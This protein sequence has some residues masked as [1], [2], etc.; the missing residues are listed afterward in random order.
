VTR[1]A[2]QDWLITGAPLMLGEALSQY[3]DLDVV[4][5]ERVT[6]ARRRMGL[7]DDAT[8]DAA[9][10]RR[11]AEE[12]G[13]WTAITGNVFASGKNL[14]LSV[15]ALDVPT[16]KVL[17]R[18][19]TE[20][21]AEADVR[22]A[23]DKLSVR[24]LEVSGVRGQ[25]SDVAA[26]T[27]QSVQAYQAYVSGV[28]LR[29][30]SAYRQAIASFKE[31][32]RLDSTFALAWAKLALTSID[33]NPLTLLDP[34]GAI[35]REIDQAA[36]FAT[37]LPARQAQEIRAMQAFYGGD[38]ARGRVLIDS[39]VATDPDD[40]ESLE[41][42][43]S[44]GMIDPRIDT[45]A[46]PPTMA[47]SMNHSLAQA[48]DVLERDPGRRNVYATLALSYGLAG[49]LWT[50]VRTGFQRVGPILSLFGQGTGSDFVPV[51]GDTIALVPRVLFDALPATERARSRRAGAE[52]AMQWVKRWLVAG[53]ADAD[54]HLWASRI[55]E[56]QEDFPL[57]LRE[58]AV[59]ESLGVQSTLES[60][61]GR[62]LVLLVRSGKF[63]AAAAM[64]ESVFVAGAPSNPVQAIIDRGVGYS[65]MSLLLAKRWSQAAALADRLGATGGSCLSIVNALTGSRGNP[66]T[67]GDLKAV[68]DTAAMHFTEVASIPSLAPC[69]GNF[70]VTLVL[71]S[72]AGRRTQAGAALLRAADSLHQAGNEI[73]AYRAAQ[74]MWRVDTARHAAFASR[75]W[76][77][78]KSRE[79]L[80]GAR[81]TAGAVTVTADSATFSFRQIAPG[82][83]TLNLVTIVTNWGMSVDMQ[84]GTG[85]TSTRMN[86]R[87]FHQRQTQDGDIRGGVPQMIQAMQTQQVSMT[88][89]NA[90]VAASR[91]ILTPTSEGFQVVLKGQALAALLRLKPASAVFSADICV[92][93]TDGL[94][95]PTSMA[96]QYR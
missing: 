75:A 45:T 37:R 2:A 5:E 33:G 42:S 41:M 90:A 36:R 87:L 32:T 30:R 15:Q 77:T 88:P 18:G 6:A 11:L 58:L 73:L 8:L 95:T 66:S 24:L 39:L 68:M 70:V 21:A 47:S 53:P 28:E 78:E 85:T 25:G 20:I 89:A 84:A 54:A 43:A 69:V 12:T 65:I 76:V 82:P 10:L 74:Y 60:V 44:L 96:I 17:V 14:R 94:C 31:A 64:A 62:R 3:R 48:R 56:V 83:M 34:D 46:S 7:K 55:A 51:M 63:D 67:Q 27:T 29:Q 1:A 13:G 57:A 92:A 40:L 91:P 72:T 61:R 52:A 22:P 81:F 71:D 19:E 59:A 79:L 16:A 35:F 93:V 4:P 23:F 38:F 80:P 9:Q 86:I 26:L 50:G 49:G